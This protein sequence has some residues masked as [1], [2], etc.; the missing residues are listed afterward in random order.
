[1]IVEVNQIYKLEDNEIVGKLRES[2]MLIEASLKLNGIKY[3]E[4]FIKRINEEVLDKLVPNSFVKILIA[5]DDNVYIVETNYQQ[6]GKIYLGMNYTEENKKGYIKLV[7][8]K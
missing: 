3:T 8:A 6:D 5:T 1:M 2:S 7:E 4:R